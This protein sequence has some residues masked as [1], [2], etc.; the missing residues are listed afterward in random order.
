MSACRRAKK[1]RTNI[2]TILPTRQQSAMRAEKN[3]QQISITVTTVAISSIGSPGPFAVVSA[4]FV[5]PDHH[6]LVSPCRHEGES[7]EAHYCQPVLRENKRL[8]TDDKPSLHST[9]PCPSVPPS[10][11]PSPPPLYQARGQYARAETLGACW[12]NTIPM[13]GAN[14]GATLFR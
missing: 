8:P 7:S 12:A 14:G 3:G 10:L 4:E 13:V 2:R 5:L 9:S 11:L 1:S 6:K